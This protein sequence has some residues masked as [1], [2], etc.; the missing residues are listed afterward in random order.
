MVNVHVENLDL[1]PFLKTK[2]TLYDV[3]YSVRAALRFTLLRIVIQL[4]TVTSLGGEK[5]F[6]NPSITRYLRVLLIVLTL[7][8]KCQTRALNK[9]E[10]IDAD[11]WKENWETPLPLSNHGH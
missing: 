8:P 4:L 2:T 7:E 10:Q 1:S 9:N 6:K 11:N 5:Q 3:V